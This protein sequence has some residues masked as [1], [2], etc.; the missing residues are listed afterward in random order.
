MSLPPNPF[1]RPFES[2]RAN[3]YPLPPNP[4]NPSTRLP[5]LRIL[6][7]RMLHLRQGERLHPGDGLRLGGRND[8]GERHARG[9]SAFSGLPL[10]RTDIPHTFFLTLVRAYLQIVKGDGVFSGDHALGGLGEG[11][12]GLFELTQGLGHRVR[13]RIVVGPEELVRA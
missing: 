3:G 6:H 7:G 13:M 4:L 10:R 9:R 12:E 2:L 5:P 1:G 11:G 8:G